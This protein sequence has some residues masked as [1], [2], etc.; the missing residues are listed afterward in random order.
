MCVHNDRHNCHGIKDSDGLAIDMY[1]CEIHCRRR[2]CKQ[3]GK[4]H[5]H[6]KETKDRDIELPSIISFIPYTLVANL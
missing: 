4:K 6:R 3:K 2:G 1:G 5:T